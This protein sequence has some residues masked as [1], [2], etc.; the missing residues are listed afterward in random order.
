ME[1]VY[2][3]PRETLFPDCYPQGLVPFADVGG[4]G[5]TLDRG[6]FL[7]RIAEHGFFVERAYAER[8]PSLKQV[9]P[10]TVLHGPDATSVEAGDETSGILVMRRKRGGGESR[11]HGKHS[12]GVGGH[13][14][15][16]DLEGGSRHAILERGS[17]REISEEISITGDLELRTHGVL[18]D[19]SNPVGAV[20]VGLVQVARFSGT[21][22]ILEED[23][24]EGRVLAPAA[25]HRLRR[26]GA[27]FETWSSILI[28]PLDQLV[29]PL[30]LHA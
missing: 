29:R 16:I 25:L 20:H 19:D 26:D 4:L 11:L 23:Q 3:V 17:L 22:R 14:N 2:V 21:L 18:N 30:S 5:A 1:F 13:L 8:S 12:I 24:L 9:I 15:P 10:Y 7:E 27:E 6:E 28:D